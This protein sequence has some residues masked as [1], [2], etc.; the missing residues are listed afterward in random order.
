MLLASVYLWHRNKP[1]VCCNIL[2]QRPLFKLLRQYFSCNSYNPYT[3]DSNDNFPSSGSHELP[4]LQD[5]R[6]ESIYSLQ[7]RVISSEAQRVFDDFAFTF[8]EETVKTKLFMEV[9]SRIYRVHKV[10]QLFPPG[11]RVGEGGCG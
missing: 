10:Q 6:K 5:A 3:S 8:Q 11:V 7:P 2:I 1:P 9:A 4:G